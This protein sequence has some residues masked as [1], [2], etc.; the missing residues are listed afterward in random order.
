MYLPTMKGHSDGK[1]LDPDAR[2]VRHAVLPGDLL[3]FAERLQAVRDELAP[4]VAGGAPCGAL[5][6]L[7][8]WPAQVLSKL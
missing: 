8:G 3:R 6:R 1:V 7:A 5:S 4:Q 2:G